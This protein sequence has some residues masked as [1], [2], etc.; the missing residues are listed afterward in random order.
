[1]EA[2]VE[3]GESNKYASVVGI[4][5]DIPWPASD[6]AYEYVRRRY[7]N[8]LAN[9]GDAMI[10]AMLLD[11][12]FDTQ[13]NA[14]Y[15]YESARH[16]FGEWFGVKKSLHVP[17]A[18]SH[19]GL[20]FEPLTADPLASSDPQAVALYDAIGNDL[21]KRIGARHTDF[22][23][24]S[25]QSLLRIGEKVF[26]KPTSELWFCSPK[27]ILKLRGEDMMASQ[28]DFSHQDAALQSA[29]TQVGKAETHISQNSH[30]TR[31][32]VVTN[33]SI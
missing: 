25:L 3:P 6:P 30:D 13:R 11:A 31:W 32:Y 14:I 4:H 2:S 12:D 16:K 28:M 1:M 22:Y 26:G 10:P 8:K 5:L 24:F 21:K 23:T 17:N 9:V 29:L 33:P 7:A 20:P 27:D 19:Y 15:A 18:D